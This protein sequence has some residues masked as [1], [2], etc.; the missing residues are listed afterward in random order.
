MKRDEKGLQS[1][2]EKRAHEFV[3][4]KLCFHKRAKSTSLKIS[5]PLKKPPGVEHI[6]RTDDAVTDTAGIKDLQLR[7]ARRAG[8]SRSLRKLKHFQGQNPYEL[9]N[10]VASAHEQAQSRENQRSTFRRKSEV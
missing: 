7:G 2:G 3:K 6:R 5:S 9:L 4:T 1:D 8:L 10:A